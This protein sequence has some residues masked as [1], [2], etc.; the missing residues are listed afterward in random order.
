VDGL[1]TYFYYSNV[2]HSLAHGCQNFDIVCAYLG[3]LVAVRLILSE[4]NTATSLDAS[5]VLF[6]RGSK[7]SIVKKVMA[8]AD[9]EKS[10]SHTEA[11]AKQDVQ[12]TRPS[13][14]APCMTD[15]FS[16]QHISYTVHAADGDQKLL[17]DVSGYVTP[18]KLTALMGESGAGK[19]SP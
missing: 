1:H 15:I 8:A 4:F 19:A 14:E 6:K 2:F 10:V 16:W 13:I 3:G 7:S 12:E 11:A 17:D 18:G 5:V 9:E